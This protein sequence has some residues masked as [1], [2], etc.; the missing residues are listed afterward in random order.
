MKGSGSPIA[1]EVRRKEAVAR[2]GAAAPKA[3]GSSHR[4]HGAEPIVITGAFIVAEFIE[5]TRA[6][7]L[8]SP[9]EPQFRR[10]ERSQTESDVFLCKVRQVLEAG[11]AQGD[12]WTSF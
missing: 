2:Q 12:R 5:R 7:E 8:Y 11:W 1:G 6:P 4:E 9:L 10:S 3:M